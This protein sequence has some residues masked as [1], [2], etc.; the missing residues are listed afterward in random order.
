VLPNR[1]I[2][3][4]SEYPFT[5][6]SRLPGP[7][8]EQRARHDEEQARKAENHVIQTRLTGRDLLF[9]LLRLSFL[10]DAFNTQEFRVEDWELLADA[11]MGQGVK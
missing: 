3:L 8:K 9:F 2:L 4:T 5:S 10:C 6:P 11:G 7:N 1:L